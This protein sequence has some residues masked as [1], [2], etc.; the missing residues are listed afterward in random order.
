MKETKAHEG[1]RLAE[2]CAEKAGEDWQSQAY[3]AFVAVA[4]RSRT[5]TTGAVRREM[6]AKGLKPHDSRAWGQI[7]RRA[8]RDGIVV[9]S[10]LWEATGSHHR[11]DA[12]WRSQIVEQNP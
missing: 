4:R 11:P 6:E 1:H 12:I 7:A 5:F 10:G 3:D 2:L 8:Y 9:H